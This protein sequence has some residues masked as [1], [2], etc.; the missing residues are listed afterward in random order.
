M[1]QQNWSGAQFG[2]FF[3]NVLDEGGGSYTLYTLSG[4]ERRHFERF[5][6]AARR[7]AVRA[8][9]PR[10]GDHPRGRC[11]EDPRV[12]TTEPHRGMPFGHL[13]VKSYLAVPVTS[14]SGDVLGGL[15]FGH[16]QAGVF[17]DTPSA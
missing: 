4:V 8:D 13:P 9:V 17:S 14:R 16:P 6:D 7:R 11:H 5:S 3:Y 15:F 1:R 10:R 12:D 2:S